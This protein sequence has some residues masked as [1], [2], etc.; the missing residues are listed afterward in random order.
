MSEP[1]DI[2]IDLGA[3]APLLPEI[4]ILREFVA[5][6][7]VPPSQVVGGVLHRA[8]KITLTGS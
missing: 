4:V 8:C 5:K 7:I 2:A 1:I 3:V 6:P